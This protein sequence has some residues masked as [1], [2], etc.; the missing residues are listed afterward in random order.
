MNKIQF[1]DAFGEVDP[2]YVLAVDGILEQVEPKSSVFTRK[3]ILSAALL[4]AVLATF[5]T[6]TAYA[7]GFFG[8]QTRIIKFPAPTIQTSIE[9]EIKDTLEHL[10]GVHH[11]DY[12]SLSGVNGSAEFQAAAEWLAFKGSYADQ[13]TREQLEKGMVYYEWRDLERSF[14]PDEETREICRLYQVWDSAMWNKLQEIAQTYN[15]KLHT[16]FENLSGDS[17]DHGVYEDGSYL[18]FV[19]A[20]PSF[21]IYVERGGSLPADDLATSSTDQYEEWEFENAYGDTVSIA[22]RDTSTDPNWTVNNVLIFYHADNA[23]VTV[24]AILNSPASDKE[25]ARTE[26]EKFADTLNFKTFTAAN[27]KETISELLKGGKK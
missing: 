11:R 16:N 24:R 20:Q 4:A 19:E 7:T 21:E 23:T 3:K 5:L 27:S 12:L 2:A 8:L 14:A 25:K 13:K 26:I 15:L 17:R 6:L 22:V 9:P 10:Q 1:F 18:A